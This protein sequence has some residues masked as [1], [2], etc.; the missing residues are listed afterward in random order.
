L[1]ANS[2]IKFES[3]LKFRNLK[4]NKKIE[5][6]KRKYPALGPTSAALG[7]SLGPFSPSPRQPAIRPDADNDAPLANSSPH[8]LYSGR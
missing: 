8:A 7:P 4:R 6:K 3:N 2:K 5:E 1:S